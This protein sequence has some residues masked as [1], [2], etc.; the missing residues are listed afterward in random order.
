MSNNH[1]VDGVTWHNILSDAQR[2]VLGVIV[3]CVVLFNN[4]GTFAD[5][6]HDFL[7]RLGALAMH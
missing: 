3:I 2:R 6:Q 4:I 7:L 5:I 1:D